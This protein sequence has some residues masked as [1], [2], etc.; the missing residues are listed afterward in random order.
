MIG[1]MIPKVLGTVVEIAAS[2]AVDSAIK[3]ATPSNV[4]TIT[5]FMIKGGAQRFAAQH[6]SFPALS[7]IRS[8][9]F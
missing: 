6:G 3:V 4:K 8:G 1:L 7:C 9:L 2:V 5:G